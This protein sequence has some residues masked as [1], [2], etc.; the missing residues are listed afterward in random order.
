MALDLGSRVRRSAFNLLQRARRTDFHQQ[1]RDIC[2]VATGL[3]DAE[4]YQRE[5]FE[6]LGRSAAQTEHYRPWA[7]KPLS[8]YPVLDKSTLRAAPD[9]FRSRL[10]ADE[11]LVQ[12][13]TS[14]SYGVPLTLDLTP[15]K[16]RRQLAEVVY[17]GEWAGY[18]VGTPHLYVRAH[19][20]KSRLKLWAQN[21]WFS[22]TNK[23][24]QAW[25]EKQIGLLRKHRIQAIIGFP[26]T[27]TQLAQTARGMDLGPEDF[28]VR[29]CITI[30][31]ALRESQ[32]EI[33]E[34]TFGGHCLSRYTSE[35]V[36]V[37]AA[38]CPEE[39]VHHINPASYIIEILDEQ[40]RPVP[41]GELGRIVVTDLFSNAMPLIRYDI[42]DLGVL[43]SGCACGRPTPYIAR[44]EGRTIE[45]IVN[46]EGT[47]L[48]PFF[49]NPI[50][51]SATGIHQFQFSQTA[52]STYEMR[53]VGDPGSDR[54]QIEADLRDILG[55]GAKL[56]FR[57][58]EEIPP[59][60]S[61]KRPYVI[62]EWKRAQSA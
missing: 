34:A 58:V 9:T 3:T 23:P 21:E 42:G 25:A 48:N 13:S 32:R 53:T 31:E 1:V 44:I 16:K 29:G 24:T 55:D 38:E 7:G 37:M 20:P 19:A 49:I 56:S 40:D 47:V 50:M 18:K 46:A 10:H 54:A 26:S 14:G 39:H 33:V 28:H 62:N 22:T 8:K 12:V 30:G 59:L 11:E 61:G 17:F 45:S 41:E 4:A 5:A 35:E 27:I 36:G 57:Q 51:K 6:Q 15:K 60:P 52:P 43:G 2:R